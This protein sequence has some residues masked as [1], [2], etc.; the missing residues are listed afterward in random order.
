M[1]NLIDS[2]H[3]VP[4]DAIPDVTSGTSVGDAL[5]TLAER[6]VDGALLVE[7]GAAIGLVKGSDLAEAIR[8][9]RAGVEIDDWSV[10]KRPVPDV[11]RAAG[12]V[13]VPVLPVPQDAT[14]DT[15]NRIGDEIVFQVTLEGQR[16]GWFLNHES[17][18]AGVF[19]PPP[20]YKCSNGHENKDPDHGFCS[21]CPAKLV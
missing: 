20:V 12:K 2:L 21:F 3:F 7:R 18:L 9:A 1:A 11:L 15:L 16:V 13:L 19:T 4:L 5:R 10:L 8:A 17:L 14:A 6:N